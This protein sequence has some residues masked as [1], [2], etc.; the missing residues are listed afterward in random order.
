MVVVGALFGG[1]VFDVEPDRLHFLLYATLA[2][3]G[4]LAAL[5]AYPHV[6]WCYEVRGLCVFGKMLLL[7][8]IPWLWAYRVPILVVVF[9]IASIGSHMP[10]RYRHFSIL[11]GRVLD[12]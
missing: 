6:S 2:T 4:V 1:H 10:R 5:E 3:G 7:C 9:V 12:T 8:S 11:H